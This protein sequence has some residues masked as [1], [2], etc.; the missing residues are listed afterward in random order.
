MKVCITEG[1]FY[2]VTRVNTEVGKYKTISRVV[3][4]PDEL[5]TRYAALEKEW[6]LVGDQIQSIAEKQ[7]H[8]QW[9]AEGSPPSRWM[10]VSSGSS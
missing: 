2:P 7:W 6:S 1:E 10:G 9:V 3:E 5:V 4:I 8:D